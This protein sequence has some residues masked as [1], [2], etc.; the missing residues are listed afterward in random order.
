M[1][2]AAPITHVVICGGGTAGWMTAAAL[3]KILRQ[4]T[5]ITLVESEEIGIVG[6]GEAT[7]PM[8]RRFNEALEIDE[9]EFVRE[10]CG[11]YKLGIEFVNWGRQGDRYMHGFGRFGPDLNTV[12]FDQYWQK[13]YQAG[14]ARE[15][16]EYMITR[17]GAYQNRFMRARPDMQGSPL[18]DIHSAFHFDASLYAKYLRKLAERRGVTRVEGKIQRAE[19]REGDGHITALVMENG[20]RVEGQLFIDCSGFRGLLIEQTLKTG[21]DN[22]SNFLPCDRALAVPCESVSPLTPYTRSTAHQAGWQW[23]I[24]LQH[25]TGNGHVYC[26]RYI[27]DDEAAAVLLRNLDGKPLADPRPLKFVT[28][29]RKK[30]WN[31]N[32]VAVGLASGFMEPLES[33]SIHLIQTAIQRLIDF[34]PSSAFEQADIDEFNAQARW[35]WERIRDFIVLHYHLNQRDDAEFWKACAHMEVPAS[36]KHRIALYESHG[37]IVRDGSELFAEVGWLQVLHGQN[38]RARGYHPLV[39]QMPE[40]D[41]EAYLANVHQVIAKCASLMPDHAAFLRDNCPAAP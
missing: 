20:S 18:A 11:S 12:P 36:L 23:R 41:V 10:T 21:Y 31:K 19:Q 29:M 28:G 15:L 17:V 7:I 37:R 9:N 33:T 5:Q 6:V 32:V 1:H 3:S 4:R 25:R 13:A 39:D 26:S 24:P 40:R 27:S 38:A 35:E 2:A 22:W 8:I 16:G 30:V 34:F 14:K